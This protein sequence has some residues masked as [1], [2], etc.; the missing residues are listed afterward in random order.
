MSKDKLTAKE[1]QN[2]LK[3]GEIGIGPKGRLI[4]KAIDSQTLQSNFMSENKKVINAKKVDINLQPLGIFK[5]WRK[6][7]PGE[8]YFDS[9]IEGQF[10]HFLKDSNIS[11]RMKEK[12]TL[13]EKFKY[14]GKTINSIVWNPDFIIESNG[15]RIIID[16][17]GHATS[18]FKLKYRMVCKYFENDAFNSPPH[19]WFVSAKYKFPIALNCIKRIFSG[20][21]LDGIEASLLF[22]YKPKKLKK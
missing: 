19:I 5:E 12:I 13:I 22:G 21:P 9:K 14:Y 18:D 20:T 6:E 1:F 2:K 3:S 11:F 17:K 16:T 7:H 15:Y 8:I 10:Y 4:S